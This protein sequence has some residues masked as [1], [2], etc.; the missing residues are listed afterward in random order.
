MVL[1]AL[2]RAGPRRPA[3]EPTDGSS[4]HAK[5]AKT[6]PKVSPARLVRGGPLLLLL[7]AVA[8][9]TPEIGDKCLLS[10]DCS[11]RG[12]RLC[13][14]SQPGGYCTQF[15]CRSN[16][17]PE[18]ASCVL[19]NSALPGCGFD[20][21]AGPTGSRVGRSFCVA[22]CSSDAD[23]REGYTCADPR[24]APWN[25]LI[26]DDDQGAR[27]CLV[28]PLELDGGVLDGGVDAAAGFSPS[29]PVCA[30][31]AP[32][33]PPIDAAPP[34]IFDGGGVAPPPPFDAGAP[35]A[36]DAGDAGDAGDASDGG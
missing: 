5:T 11:I 17:C 29:A 12:D 16:S 34:Q 18:E 28:R 24:T 20:D 1:E 31:V 33:V 32:E 14:T 22:R 9:C 6:S 4:V 35:D 19:F 2:L 8:A 25:A 13:D 26:L 30:P 7:A 23:C 15:N 3:G 27:T 21:R 10:T 36:A